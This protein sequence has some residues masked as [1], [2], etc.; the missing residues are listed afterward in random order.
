MLAQ[1][2]I[3]PV[4][5]GI[6][7]S[8]SDSAGSL[9]LLLAASTEFCTEV[10]L[11]L[12]RTGMPLHLHAVTKSDEAIAALTNHHFDCA[13]IEDR[14]PACHGVSDI[15][16]WRRNGIATPIVV[17]VDGKEPGAAL[18]L[19]EAGAADCLARTEINGDRLLLSLHAA[20]RANRM[21]E[22]LAAA[23]YKLNNLTLRDSLTKLP[24]RTLFLDRLEQIL[25]TVQ[26]EPRGI[27]LVL[28]D[29][30]KFSE[31]NQNFGHHA[32]DRLLEQV[33]TRLNSLL[34]QSDRLA[35][36][37][38]DQFAI[39][40]PANGN[41]ANACALAQK[42]TDGFAKSFE[43]GNRSI[44]VTSATGIALYPTHGATADQL[45]RAACAAVRA[46]KL[47]ANAY[48]FPDSDGQDPTTPPSLVQELRRAVK[49]K[50]FVFFYQPIIDMRTE[51]ISG[52]EALIRWRHAD[53]GMIAP[54][55]FIPLAEQIGLIDA[56]TFWELDEAIQQAVLW[57]KSGLDLSISIN[58][59][60]LSLRNP[61]L[62][63]TVEER[64]SYWNLPA[65]NI[66][67]EI[68]ET[69][70][71]HDAVGAAETLHKLR[72]LGISIAIDDFGTGYTSLSYLRKLPLG[73]I[74]IDKSFVLNMRQSSDDAIIVRTII[75]LGKSLGLQVIAEGVEDRETWTTLQDMGCIQAQGYYMSR[76]LPAVTVED[77]LK[78]S[79]FGFGQLMAEPILPPPAIHQIS[80]APLF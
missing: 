22:R 3:N 7:G 35:R 53:R 64:L 47:N 11:A 75:E 21:E 42:I 61:R 80:A 62:I 19:V 60:A 5:D 36:V 74:K 10:R 17:M 51:R 54:D 57:R 69:A 12:A 6:S 44:P 70:I 49:Q 59:S 32:G 34:G 45:L 29:L 48:S 33:A 55:T 23:E 2:S 56:I 37:G 40:M 26:R 38:D 30:I 9:N 4:N 67:L 24:S 1:A 58:L 27:A 43:I 50:E 52:M 71:I 20:I 73:R 14:I 65:S 39:I 72:Q 16:A 66:T 76:P 77:W 79:P 41:R 15:E 8:I 68:T 18:R 31:I 13:L 63:A 46:T 78:T 25:L 28:V